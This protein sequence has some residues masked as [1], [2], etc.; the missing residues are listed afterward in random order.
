M[1]YF[2]NGSE[3]SCFQSEWCDRCIH[4]RQYRSTGEGA[5]CRVWLMHLSY[6]SPSCKPGLVQIPEGE[7]HGP[8]L[9]LMLD[10]LIEEDANGRLTCAMFQSESQEAELEAAGQL[11]L[12]PQE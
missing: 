5:G 10:S 6:C 3:G 1:A 4:E 8:T 9:R 11:T 12:A 2:A 7:M